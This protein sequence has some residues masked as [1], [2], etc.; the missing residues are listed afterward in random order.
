MF[1]KNALIFFIMTLAFPLSA[2][3]Q[4]NLPDPPQGW[5]RGH[6]YYH[7]KDNVWDSAVL[8]SVVPR[9]IPGIKVET[10]SWK[11]KS[12]QTLQNRNQVGGMSFADSNFEYWGLG[13]M[14]N[15]EHVDAFSKAMEESGFFGGR[16]NDSE[17]NTEYAWVGHGFYAY[18][19]VRPK[20]LT[21][22]EDGYGF[23]VSFSITPLVHTPPKSF[24]GWPLPQVGAVLAPLSTW[25]MM[26]WD[27][28]GT[29]SE[30]GWDIQS[31][32]GALPAG[33]GWSA[34][35][36]YSSVSNAQAEAYAKTLEANGWKIAYQDPENERGYSAQLKKDNLYARIFFDR[37]HEMKVGFATM[38]ELL[39]Y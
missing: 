12:H 19:S 1:A 31:D 28:N 36:D 10:T 35:F 8:P 24:N 34:W 20:Y 5:Q 14:A 2:S 15:Q 3:G 18:A 27:E 16:I 38:A 23:N 13:F 37:R 11:A 6:N 7:W 33:K 21:A 29:D 39:D 9:E 30:I 32:K 26:S 4:S 25:T 22:G 17:Y